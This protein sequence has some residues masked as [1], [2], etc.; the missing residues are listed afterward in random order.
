MKPGLTTRNNNSCYNH[1][2]FNAGENKKCLKPTTSTHGTL[3][4][5]YQDH[6]NHLAEPLSMTCL[7]CFHYEFH[8]H[9]CMYLHGLPRCKHVSRGI[10]SY[11]H[12]KLVREHPN[13]NCCV[14]CSDVGV[15]RVVT[16]SL[17]YV[18]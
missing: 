3:M 1:Y 11:Q 16:H 13:I 14:H 10:D 8:P 5:T 12:Q 15:L 9:C 7:F 17:R 18:P 2:H 6:Q 4:F